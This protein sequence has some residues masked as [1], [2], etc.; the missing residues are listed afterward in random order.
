MPR[1][2]RLDR[3]FPAILMTAGMLIA[4][5]PAAAVDIPVSNAGFEADPV[6]MGCFAVFTPNAWNV[7]DPGGISGGGDVVGGLHPEG[8]PYFAMA[9]EG[10]H[11]AIVFLQGDIGG[12]PMGL[13]QTLSETLLPD[14]RYTLSVQ[15]GDIASGT[16]PPPCDIFGFFDLDGFPGYQVQL[17]AG[18][19]VIAEDDNSLAPLLSDGVFM[20]TTLEAVIDNAHPQL[21]Q[22][23]EIRLINLN[24]IDTPEHPGIEVDFDDVRLSRECRFNGDIDD[25]GT[26]DAVD[27]GIFVNVLLGAD[28]DEA[29]IERSDVNCSGT[30]D[31]RDVA[32]MVAHLLSV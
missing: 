22:P 23:L 16:G 30:V 3:F 11:V 15:I 21:G 1:Q 10:D 26:I 24:M 12:A 5:T 28:T 19:V 2:H 13:S 32:E 25:N 18:G 31:G 6:A 4:A 27:A 20:E 8:G 14:Q 9:P 7:F 29:H 17:L